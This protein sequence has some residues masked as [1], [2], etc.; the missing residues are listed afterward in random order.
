MN[1]HHADT[2]RVSNAAMSTIGERIKRARLA[3]NM[4]G[5]ELAVG[6]GYKNQSAIG[7]LEN[8][9]GGTGG[10]KLP[11]IARKLRVP[12]QWLIEGPDD[13]EIPFLEP[14]ATGA[15]PEYSTQANDSK[16][17]ATS[18]VIDASVLE[19]VEL[20]KALKTEQRLKAINYMRELLSAPGSGTHQG[21]VGESDSV[22]HDKAA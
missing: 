16:N 22:P 21:R 2:F 10:K 18:Y 9:G 20:F 4:S 12:L 11:D 6:V 7:N 15:Q 17:P 3:Q 14:I 1:Q 13:G 19:A 8:R 5:E